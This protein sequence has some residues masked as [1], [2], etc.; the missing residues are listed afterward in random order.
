MAVLDRCYANPSPIFQPAMRIIESITNSNP[1]IVTTTFNHDFVTGT[2]VRLDIPPADGMQQA[3]GMTGAI[4]VIS[5]DTFEIDIDTTHFEPF[6]IPV[7]PLQKQQVCA[8]VVPIGE[9]NQILTAAT[10]NVLPFP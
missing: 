10:Q 6:A 8:Q 9:V 3:N 7:A 1:A 4:V 2:I 5:G